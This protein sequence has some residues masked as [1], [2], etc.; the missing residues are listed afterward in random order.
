[1]KKW[2]TYRELFDALNQNVE[3]IVL[4]NF[5]RLHEEKLVKG[6]EDIDLLCN[7]K[8]KVLQVTGAIPRDDNDDGIRFVVIINNKRVSLDVREVGDGYYY[9]KWQ[10]DMLVKR[11]KKHDMFYTM[12]EDNYF[13]SIIYHVLIQ[14]E[15]IAYDYER[16]LVERAKNKGINIDVASELCDY[17]IRYME[18]KEYYVTASKSGVFYLNTTRVPKRLLRLSWGRIMKN[19]KNR[20]RELA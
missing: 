4:R 1:M 8:R 13:Y 2:K 9:S 6:H 3:Y 7:N 14:K 20:L 10:K 18:K 5:E 16:E 17:L 11:V 19:T 12:D 15:Y